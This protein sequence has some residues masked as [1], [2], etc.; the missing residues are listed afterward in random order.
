[1]LLA[2]IAAAEVAFWVVLGA[3]LVARYLL[4]RPRLGAALLICVPLVD[5]VLL[6][7]TVVDLHGG[8]VATS[9]HGLAAAYLGFSVAFGHSMMRWADQR[10]AY[11]FAGGPPPWRPPRGGRARARYEWRE[12]SRAVLAWAIACALLG[13]AVLAV[14]SPDRTREL[15]AWIGRLTLVIVVWFVAFPLWATL[16]P[17][18]DEAAQPHGDEAAQPRGDEAARPRG[19]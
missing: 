7:A 15:V 13:V 18:R 16:S 12:W 8:A 11:R 10:F 9:A 17:R 14:D 19:R 3:G 6:V 5:L 4:R 1:M 2:V